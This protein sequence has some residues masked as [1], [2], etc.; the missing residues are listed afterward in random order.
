M[1][2]YRRLATGQC[3]QLHSSQGRYKK[4]ALFLV[5]DLKVGSYNP[6][7]VPIYIRMKVRYWDEM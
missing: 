4:K 6:F 3:G 5:R 2:H 1:Q 7:V